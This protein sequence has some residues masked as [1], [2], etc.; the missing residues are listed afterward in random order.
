MRLGELFKNYLLPSAYKANMEIAGLTSDSRHVR[1]GYLFAA[2]PGVETNGAKFIPD[3][4]ARGAQI[5]LTPENID[6][7]FDLPDIPLLPDANPRQKLAQLAAQFFKYAP[8]HIAAVTGTNGKSS[9][10]EF[11]RQIWQALGCQAASMGTLGVQAEN[12]QLALEHTTP[13][14]IKL[15]TILRDMAAMDITHLALEASSHGLAQY[16]LDGVTLKAAGFTNLSRDHLDYH[17]C[18]ED[19]FAAKARLF[20]EVLDT[21]GVAVIN[22]LGTARDMGME[23]EK[24]ARLTGHACLTIDTENADLCVTA[25]Q[26]QA[27]SLSFTLNYKRH[28]LPLNL[29]LAGAFQA[30]NIAL[31][32]GLCLAMGHRFADIAPHLPHL[33]PPAGRMERIAETPKGAVVYVDYAHTPDALQTALISL[34]R[35]YKARLQKGQ[36]V[37]V[38][39][40]GGARDKDKRPQMGQIAAAE[41]DLSIITDDNPRTENPAQIRKAILANCANALEIADRGEA[42]TS[43][44]EQAGADDIILVAGKGHECVQIIGDKHL[45]FSDKEIILQFVEASHSQQKNAKKQ[46]P[47]INGGAHD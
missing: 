16:R 5:I 39:G 44:L 11:T 22:R 8:P 6:Q 27:D 29:P 19:Y 32:V 24:I 18:K 2:L 47:N 46:T 25:I 31:A 28:S 42:I 3:A 37:C 17:A 34:R 13:E 30:E 12:Y 9:V 36:L 38:F 26:P 1:P 23:I 14:P 7:N 15:H 41:A 20:S 35:Q 43:A 40:C 10:V 4:I 45:P 33:H 21:D